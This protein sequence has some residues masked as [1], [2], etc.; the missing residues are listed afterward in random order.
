MTVPTTCPEKLLPRSF[1]SSF[2]AAEYGDL[3]SLARLGKVVSSRRDEAGYSPLHFAAQQNNASATAL[4]LQLGCP[5][6]TGGGCAGGVGDNTAGTSSR[7]TEYNSQSTSTSSEDGSH[8]RPTTTTTICGA[9]PLHRAAYSGAVASMYVLLEWEKTTSRRRRSEEG[10][11]TTTATAGVNTPTTDTD[12]KCNLLAKD[13]SFQD[14][15]TPLHK[16]AAGGR[17]LAVHLLLEALRERCTQNN[18]MNNNNN[19]LFGTSN[20][21]D[22]SMRRYND[23]HDHGG[24]NNSSTSS[25]SGSSSSSSSSMLSLALHS[26]DRSGR[27]PLDVARYYYTIQETERQAVARWDEVAGGVADWGK[28]VQLLEAATAAIATVME[29]GVQQGKEVTIGTPIN[30]DDG[31]YDNPGIGTRILLPTLPSHLIGGIDACVAGNVDDRDGSASLTA[32][33]VVEFQT[34]LDRSMKTTLAAAAAECHPPVAGSTNGDPVGI[35]DVISSVMDDTEADNTSSQRVPNKDS[36]MVPNKHPSTSSLS[37]P[38]TSVANA[39]CSNCHKD[40]IVLYPLP[41]RVGLVCKACRR[42]IRRK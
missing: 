33:W 14:D 16:A 31:D 22:G 32:L 41:L 36:P 6:D 11:T 26:V 40:T 42:S 21:L 8:S 13:I 39:S 24:S 17:Y 35:H 9:T 38:A 5:V 2:T 4:L 27:T 23:D 30:S 37:S 34:A 29:E 15:S 19:I 3:P 10:T 18:S 20:S 12:R 7:T 28:C 25:R 1:L